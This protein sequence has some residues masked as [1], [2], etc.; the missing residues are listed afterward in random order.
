MMD[1]LAV[2]AEPCVL[3]CLL[4]IKILHE[5]YFLFLS[6][7]LLQAVKTHE[8]WCGAVGLAQMFSLS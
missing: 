4:E 6:E 3:T 8:S 7:F 5:A 2:E 1:T